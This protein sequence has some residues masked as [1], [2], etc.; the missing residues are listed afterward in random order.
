MASHRSLPCFQKHPCFAGFQMDLAE[1]GLRPEHEL[2][3]GSGLRPEHEP[4]Y[5]PTCSVSSYAKTSQVGTTAH[6]IFFTLISMFRS[7]KKQNVC[8]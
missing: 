4:G 2:E 3:H 6:T 7:F 5:L 8:M 1:P